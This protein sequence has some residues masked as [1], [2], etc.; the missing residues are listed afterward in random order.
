G[1]AVCAGRHGPARPRARPPPVRQ[2]LVAAL[3]ACAICCLVSPAVAQ[4]GREAVVVVVDGASLPDLLA[5]PQLRALAAEGGVAV[6]NGRSDVREQLYD[7]SR[8]R[9]TGGFLPI[10]FT[11]LEGAS[12]EEAAASLGDTLEQASGDVLVMPVSGTPVV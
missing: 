5:N 4:E 8:S 12:P 10:L 1:E 6:M 9:V 7:V 11:D 2:A 3:I